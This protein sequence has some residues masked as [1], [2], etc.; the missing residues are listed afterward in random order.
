V[1]FE[2]L[3]LILVHLLA[4]EQQHVRI[5]FFERCSGLW[6]M[7]KC[8]GLVTTLYEPLPFPFCHP[9][10]TRISYL[11]ALTGNHACGSQ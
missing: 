11:T 7:S 8:L 2:T 6:K 9:E 4:D 5:R 3:C 1:L 10:R